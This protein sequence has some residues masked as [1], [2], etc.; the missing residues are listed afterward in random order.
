MAKSESKYGLYRGARIVPIRAPLK[1]I[2]H[3][4]IGRHSKAPEGWRTPRRASL[5][6][7]QRASVLD[8]GGPP[9]LSHGACEP[10]TVSS[11]RRLLA[12]QSPCSA[13][14]GRDG[15]T[16]GGV[17]RSGRLLPDLRRNTAEG[18]QVG[19][20]RAPLKTITF[21]AWRGRRDILRSHISRRTTPPRRQGCQSHIWQRR[22]QSPVAP[23][24]TPGRS[25]ESFPQQASPLP[26][27]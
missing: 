16:I 15:L 8:C 18:G 23:R 9:P 25:R 26:S 6:I 14:I 3:S 24:P 27:G 13:W 7:R 2:S 19:T 21:E 10:H 5:T 1:L 4:P 12:A 11:P 22:W 20:T 17:L